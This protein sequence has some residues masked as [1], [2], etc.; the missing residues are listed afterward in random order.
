MT[1]IWK[2]GIALLLILTLVLGMVP[3]A[4]AE[5]LPLTRGDVADILLIAADDY[6]GGIKR[7]DILKGYPGGDLAEAQPVTRVQVLAMLVRAFGP[8]PAPTGDSARSAFP[9]R[10]FTDIPAWAVEELKSVLTA[11]IV[12]GASE[13][14][15]APDATVT[16]TELERLIR[17]V[18]ALLGTNLKDDF[19][20]AVNKDWLDT[21]EIPA[22]Q[23][24]GSTFSDVQ[25]VTDQ[26]VITLIREIAAGTPEPGTPEAKIAAFYQCV[27]DTET[28]ERMGAAPIRPY[29][30]AIEAAKTL[31]DLMEVNNELIRDLCVSPLMGFELVTDAKDSTRYLV[32][33]THLMPDMDRELYLSGT[34]A[35]RKAYLDFLERD[36]CLAGL[37]RETAR[38]RAKQSYDMDALIAPYEL[39]LQSQQDVD[40]TYNLYSFAQL[41]A[42]FPNVDLKAVYEAGGLQKTDK[43]MVSDVAAM[44]A[45]AEQFDDTHVE[46]LKAEMEVRLIAKLGGYLQQAFLDS[47]NQLAEEYYGFSFSQSPEDLAALRVET[48]LDEYLGQSYVNRYF[49]QESKADVE[50]MIQD[51]LKLYARRIRNLDWMS[52]ETKTM[53]LKKLETMRVKVGYPDHWSG[54]LDG[55]EIKSPAEGGNYFDNTMAIRRAAHAAEL[56]KQNQP[57]DKDAWDGHPYTVNAWYDSKCNDITFPAAILQAPLYDVNASREENLGGIGFVIAHEITHAFDNNG[58]KFDENGNAVDW[59]TAEDYAAF[60]SRCERVINWYDG[61]EAVPG[62][63]CNGSQTISENVADL[64]AIACITEAAAELPDPDYEA[65]YQAVARLWKTTCTRGYQE[66]LIISDLHAP[67]KLRANRSLQTVEQFYKTF[68]IKPGD[69]MWTAP[70]DRVSIW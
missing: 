52:D 51:F 37:D 58:A 30:D 67:E 68:G 11:G 27:M 49:S 41:Q 28:R 25:A 38:T 53:A 1:R 40:Q 47:S 9:D 59:W 39:D 36:L 35:K 23:I 19:Y 60:Q 29:L 64:G 63:A 45:A 31:D 24:S 4:A 22:G 46:G 6:H 43:I 3:A 21:A 48:M 34:E 69:G 5:E 44:K 70:E 17:R 61:W 65:L 16:K 12:E 18:Y 20:A 56:A 10:A 66:S 8:L 13:T 54:Y 15:L 50:N 55:V 42:V 7:T 62:I 26:R 2:R 57:V 33:F 14:A 32:S